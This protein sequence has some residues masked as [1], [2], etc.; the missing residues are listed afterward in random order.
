MQDAGVKPRDLVAFQ[1][2][3]GP[4]FV[5]AL[6][7]TQLTGA[8]GVP[9]RN[10]KS[11]STVVSWCN[12]LQVKCLLVATPRV[13]IFANRLKE[14]QCRIILSPDKIGENKYQPVTDKANALI[15]HTSGTTA[16]PKGVIQPAHTIE[17][18]TQLVIDHLNYSDEDVVY[19]AGEIS[20]GLGM[21]ASMLPIFAVGGTLLTIPK[22]AVDVVMDALTKHHAT[23]VVGAPSYLREIVEE[24]KQRWPA[25]PKLRLAVSAADILP[26]GLQADWHRVFH[27]P[28]IDCYGGT[29]VCGIIAADGEPFRGTTFRLASDDELWVKG[30]TL[31]DGYWKDAEQTRVAMVDG[32]WYRTGDLA[33]RDELGCYRIIGRAKYIIKSKGVPISPAVIEAALMRHESVADCIVAG[34]RNEFGD[35]DIEAFIVPKNAFSEDTLRE[36]AKER[37]GS[38]RSPHRYW[39]VSQIPRTWNG[40][41]DRNSIE[42]LRQKVTS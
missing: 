35:E 42:T 22:F 4:D 2:S 36:Y 12:H 20:H 23:V 1:L 34:W 29:E 41:I 14:V 38:E 30:N 8:I 33:V 40:K 24:A 10:S 16:Y 32:N 3:N 6:V 15:V 19:S 7:A 13:D 21:H 18:H 27:T 25:I 31:F 5:V 11:N 39:K 37:L 17:T 28:L 26:P 9:I